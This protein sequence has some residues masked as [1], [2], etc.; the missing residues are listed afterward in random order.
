MGGWGGRR[1]VEQE[2]RKQARQKK[3]W[4]YIIQAKATNKKVS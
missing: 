1:F 2:K 3:T 4:F